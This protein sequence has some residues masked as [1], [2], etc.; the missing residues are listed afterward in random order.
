MVVKGF[1]L[2]ACFPLQINEWEGMS[3]EAISKKRLPSERSLLLG[4]GTGSR[5]LLN[6][7]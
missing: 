4:G 2:F 1:P 5:H 6:F 3:Q 7:F